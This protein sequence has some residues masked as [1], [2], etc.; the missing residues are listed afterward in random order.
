M[1]RP[2]AET[3]HGIEDGG[4]HEE[5]EHGHWGTE[6]DGHPA[7][8]DDVVGVGDPRPHNQAGQGAAQEGAGGDPLSVRAVSHAGRRTHLSWMS[9]SWPALH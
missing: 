9:G 8:A 1:P 3:E 6:V 5:Q 2:P 7:A 4:Q